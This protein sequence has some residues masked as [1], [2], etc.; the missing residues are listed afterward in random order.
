M[1]FTMTQSH[2]AAVVARWP[3]ASNRIELLCPEGTDVADPI[4]G[5][6]DAYRS[7]ADQ[8]DVH[9]EARLKDLDIVAM[10]GKVVSES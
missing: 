9:V 2:R 8:I 10:V 1:I 4:G 6:T 3:E 7:C 5:P